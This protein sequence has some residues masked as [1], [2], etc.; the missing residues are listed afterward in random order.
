M[1]ESSQ[2]NKIPSLRQV[3]QSVADLIVP[4]YKISRLQAIEI[5][6]LTAQN[7]KLT[8]KSIT[9]P[10]T[11]LSNVGGFYAHSRAYVKTLRR[12]KYTPSEIREALPLEQLQRETDGRSLV[13]VDLDNFKP[14]ND[15]KGHAAGDRVLKN[16]AQLLKKEI[17]PGDEVF[18][19]G[20]DEFLIVLAT[21]NAKVA[22]LFSRRLQKKLDDEHNLSLRESKVTAT[23]TVGFSIVNKEGRS[24][25]TTAKKWADV[26]MYTNKK[27]RYPDD[28]L[29]TSVPPTPMRKMV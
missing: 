14:I 19:I 18:R 13:I 16:I 1:S 24:P 10:L 25:I 6:N 7:T 9:D 11:G 23:A 4:F 28:K 2:K 8:E 3:W 27:N 17:R 20:G 22:K 21:D 12:H 29:R 15:N 26:V 5:S